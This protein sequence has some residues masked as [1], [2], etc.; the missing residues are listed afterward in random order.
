MKL[1]QLSPV[2][3]REVGDPKV[4]SYGVVRSVP[5]LGVNR[6]HELTGA[7]TTLLHPTTGKFGFA[8]IQGNGAQFAP[9][10]IV[11]GGSSYS[12][13]GLDGVYNAGITGLFERIDDDAFIGG[14]G[15][16]APV[17]NQSVWKLSC[18]T[19]HKGIN[20]GTRT[21]IVGYPLQFYKRY[22][23]DYSF[24]LEN[25]GNGFDFGQ[26]DDKGMGIFQVHQQSGYTGNN[27]LGGS[28]PVQIY[29]TGSKLYGITRTVDSEMGV[30]N[31]DHIEWGQGDLQTLNHGYEVVSSTTY[32]DLI[33]DVFIDDRPIH[34]GGLG[35]VKAT[36]NG[37][38]FIDYVGPT[39]WPAPPGGVKVQPVPKFGMYLSGL[40]GA[41]TDDVTVNSSRGMLANRAMYIRK[42]RVLT[43]EDLK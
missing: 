23:F 18:L 2:P 21:E 13:G 28:P 33:I 26:S 15:E 37:K 7:M 27:Q 14:S 10:G 25:I 4:S 24:R 32:R 36:L 19:T 1:A 39:C 35:Y 22:I 6:L 16:Q 8:T 9:S 43:T 40:S 17:G 34:Q 30:I 12:A 38:P 3:E 41:V 29:L 42:I 11:I 20:G 5:D 31:G